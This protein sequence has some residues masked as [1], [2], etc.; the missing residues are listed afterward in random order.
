[1]QGVLIGAHAVDWGLRAFECK[2][3]VQ[4][5]HGASGW[6]EFAPIYLYFVIALRQQ[7]ATTAG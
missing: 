1:V 2:I 4:F 7:S 3:R 5:D 6:N